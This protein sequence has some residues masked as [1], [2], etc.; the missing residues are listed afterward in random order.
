MSVPWN[1]NDYSNDLIILIRKLDPRKVLILSFFDLP[2]IMRRAI[3]RYNHKLPKLAETVL[4]CLLLPLLAFQCF[5]ICNFVC[6]S[7][8]EMSN[9]TKFLKYFQL[10]R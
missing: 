1:E 6:S 10:F 5:T 4:E 9:K 3:K 7:P 8:Y 2:K